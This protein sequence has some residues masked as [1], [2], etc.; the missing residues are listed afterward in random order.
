MALI[1]T[2]RMEIKGEK[3]HTPLWIYQLKPDGDLMSICSNKHT[4]QKCFYLF[5][6]FNRPEQV[7]NLNTKLLRLQST[8]VSLMSSLPLR[9]LSV[10]LNNLPNGKQ[11]IIKQMTDSLISSPGT[12]IIS[13][14]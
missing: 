10:V 7:S 8:L 6:L 3:I 11:P 9:S 1:R 2:A 12:S 4:I 14:Q 13:K 5:S